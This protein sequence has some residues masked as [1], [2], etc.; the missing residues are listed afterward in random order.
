M[1]ERGVETGTFTNWTLVGDTLLNF[2]LAGDDVDIAGTNALPGEADKLFVHSGIYGAYLGQ[3][4]YNG[5][6]VNGTLSQTVPTIAGQQLLV[7]FWLTSVPDEQNDPPTN[8]FAVKWNGSTLFMQTNVPVSGWTN[9]QCIVS[10]SGSSGTLQFE[11]NNT[12]GAFGL[13]DVTVETIPAP[14]LTSVVASGG[15]IA[16]SWGAFPNVTYQV[17]ATTNMFKY[18]WT[19]LGS[20]ILATSNVVSI[21]EP[22]GNG[23]ERFYRVEIV[24]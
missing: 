10:S 7:S 5:D 9:M 2:A 19:N 21:S 18:A 22:V 24:P 6:P 23:P 12:P 20:P 1:W 17:Q 14:T 11:F 16:L 13:D 4:P 8:A 15:T 3:W